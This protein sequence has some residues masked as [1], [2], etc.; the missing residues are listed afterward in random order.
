MSPPRLDAVPK[1]TG[2]ARYAVD[3]RAPGM[4]YSAVVRSERAHAILRG[5]D[6]FARPGREGSGG[7]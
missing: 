4:L 2:R 3:F 7:E 6:A 5:I 1:V